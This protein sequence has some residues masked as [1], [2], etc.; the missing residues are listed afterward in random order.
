MATLIDTNVLID[1]FHTGS[2]FE[3]WSALRLAGARRN[4]PGV[5]N[6]QI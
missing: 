4:R 1:V 2:A 5:L 3:D 6:T